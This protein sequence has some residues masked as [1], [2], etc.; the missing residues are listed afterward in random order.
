MNLFKRIFKIGS[1]KIEPEISQSETKENVETP[2]CEE[3]LES[4]VGVDQSK[5]TDIS[6]VDLFG[7][8]PLEHGELKVEEMETEEDESESEEIRSENIE[9]SELH[10]KIESFNS[11]VHQRQ[12]KRKDDLVEYTKSMINENVIT[13][14]GANQNEIYFEIEGIRVPENGMIFIR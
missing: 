4:E 10:S 1:K 5:I 9:I 7:I 8:E 12:W 14:T 11:L 3:I 13:K 6:F 2:Q